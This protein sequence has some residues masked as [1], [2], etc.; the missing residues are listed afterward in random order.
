MAASDALS[1]VPFSAPSSVI[2]LR[3]EEGL[4]VYKAVL[5]SV[6]GITVDV[7]PG[8]HVIAEARNAEAKQIFQVG[9]GILR[10]L[11]REPLLHELEQQ[12]PP[13]FG[14]HVIFPAKGIM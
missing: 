1:I 13:I 5:I 2:E 4:I 6:G 11:M 3:Q 12:L 9:I 14:A 10:T 7:V 8:V